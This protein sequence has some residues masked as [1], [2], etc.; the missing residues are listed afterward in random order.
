MKDVEPIPSLAFSIQAL[1]RLYALLLGSG[2][3]R[4]ANVP[5]GWNVVLDFIGN[6]AAMEVEGPKIAINGVGRIIGPNPTTRSFP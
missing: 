2:I 1:P 5:T 6:L 4:A 3:S